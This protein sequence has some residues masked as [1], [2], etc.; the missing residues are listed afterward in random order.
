MLAGLVLPVFSG[1]V[2]TSNNSTIK[3]KIGEAITVVT[4]E[5]SSVVIG[6]DRKTKTVV[7]MENRLPVFTYTNE[8]GAISASQDLRYKGREETIIYSGEWL[9]PSGRTVSKEGKTLYLEKFT[10][11]RFVRLN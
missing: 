9:R 8:Q 5:N 3:L 10:G 4:G 11:G 1:C 6:A 7:I 2:S